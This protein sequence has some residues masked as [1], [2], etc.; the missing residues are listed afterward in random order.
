MTRPRGSAPL[1]HL[2]LPSAVRA[3]WAGNLPDRP[4]DSGQAGTAWH[5]LYLEADIPLGCGVRVLL[6]ASDDVRPGRPG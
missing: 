2:S 6:A 5:R 1:H 4:L 3:G